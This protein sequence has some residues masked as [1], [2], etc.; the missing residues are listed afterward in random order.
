ML[1]IAIHV[2]PDLRSVCRSVEAHDIFQ[3]LE[4]VREATPF[5][6]EAKSRIIMREY[7]EL[8]SGCGGDLP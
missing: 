6:S 8:Q 4:F 2:T 7:K 1:E 3:D 5:H